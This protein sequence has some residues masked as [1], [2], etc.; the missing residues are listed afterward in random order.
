MCQIP[1]RFVK[2]CFLQLFQQFCEFLKN[3]RHRPSFGAQNCHPGDNHLPDTDT[4]CENSK[5][6]TKP[7]K[8][9]RTCLGR[10]VPTPDR[11]SIRR[12][13]AGSLMVPSRRRPFARYRYVF[14]NFHDFEASKKGVNCRKHK[15]SGRGGR[16]A[17]PT[18]RPR[19]LTY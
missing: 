3:T 8:V 14:R 12:L 1:I 18:T 4:I 16:P 15:N 19:P 7:K 6:T 17:G 11:D 9:F 5:K 10:A 13:S 2:F